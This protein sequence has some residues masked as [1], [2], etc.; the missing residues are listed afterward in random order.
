MWLFMGVRFRGELC[1]LLKV[2]HFGLVWF[3]DD[4]LTD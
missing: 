3:W 4:V 1:L 2:S